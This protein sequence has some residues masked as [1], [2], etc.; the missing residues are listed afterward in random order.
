MRGK[1][2]GI[3]KERI[4]Y[5]KGNMITTWQAWDPTITTTTRNVDLKKWNKSPS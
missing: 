2:F 1:R 3:I 4:A 5:Q